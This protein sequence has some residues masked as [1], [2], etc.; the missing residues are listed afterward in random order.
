MV[1]AAPAIVPNVPTGPMGRLAQKRRCQPMVPVWVGDGV[2]DDRL[3]GD[4]Q[5]P[6]ESL[7]GPTD[8]QEEHVG[9][10]GGESRTDHELDDPGDEGFLAAD[11][12]AEPHL[13]SARR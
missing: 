9:C 6:P 12:V 1:I 5:R 13:K 7:H 11:E 4:H 10:A 3:H 8:H 2:R